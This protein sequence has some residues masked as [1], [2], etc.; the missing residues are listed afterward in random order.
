MM[1]Y[2]RKRQG[3]DNNNV[4]EYVFVLSHTC[5]DWEG[6]RSGWI[7]LRVDRAERSPLPGLE[8]EENVSK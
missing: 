1:I 4:C 7:E 8:H 6:G 3:L 2:K 5:I